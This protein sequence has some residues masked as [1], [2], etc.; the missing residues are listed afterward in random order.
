MRPTVSSLPR[1]GTTV[2]SRSI[3]APA[4]I[5][6]RELVSL[7]ARLTGY[8]GRV[9]WDVTK[10]DGQPRRALDVSRA[11]E[12]FGFEARTPLEE[13]LAATIDWHRSIGAGARRPR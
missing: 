2:R 13:G 6:I 10:P 11:R 3:L 7:I 5:T 12:A 1:S 9:T 8:R 4:E